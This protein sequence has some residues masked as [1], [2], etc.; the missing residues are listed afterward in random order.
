MW[1][2]RMA[3]SATSKAGYIEAIKKIIYDNLVT[4]A[5]TYHAS[6]PQREKRDNEHATLAKLNTDNGSLS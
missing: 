5:M 1:R 4:M 2:K 6:V 3:G